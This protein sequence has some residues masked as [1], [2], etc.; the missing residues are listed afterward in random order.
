MIAAAGAQQLAR[1]VRHGLDIGCFSRV[2]LD[3]AP[4]RVTG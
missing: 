3:A 4:W 1:G 2:P